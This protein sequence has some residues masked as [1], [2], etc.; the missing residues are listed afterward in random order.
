MTNAPAEHIRRSVLIVDD[1]PGMR[2]ALHANFLRHGW[3]ARTA[4]GT[5]E[6][7]LTLSR[8]DFDLVVSDIRMRDGDGFEV[9]NLI[10]ENSPATAVILLTA[11][12]SVPEAVESMRN[13]ALDYLTKPVS[14]IQ[15]QAAATRIMQHASQQQTL[16]LIRVG[17][18]QD[19]KILSTPAAGTKIAD[20]EKQHLA[21]TLALTHGN[22][23]RTAQ[24]LGISL[25]TVRNKIREYGLPPRSY[26]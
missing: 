13:G 20:V 18:A 8:A 2:T 7:T 21:N 9:L 19:A 11:F 23:T 12:G 5:T 6:A 4:N 15:L 14:F 10:R 26:A 3:N 24:M 17:V 22:R 1:E 25:R 16:P